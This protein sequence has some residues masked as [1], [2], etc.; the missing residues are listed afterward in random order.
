MISLHLV[1]ALRRLNPEPKGRELAQAIVDIFFKDMDRS[2]RELGVTDLGVPNKIKKMG[3]AFYGLLGVLDTALNSGRSA[4]VQDVLLRNIQ[5]IDATGA[6]QLA[7]YLLA[8]SRRL[9]ATP[10]D[11]LFVEQAETA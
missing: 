3:N 4:D 9:A 8:E 11:K 1:L 2:L 10:T 6:T 5:G 7:D